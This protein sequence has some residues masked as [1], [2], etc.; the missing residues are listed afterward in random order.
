[1]DKYYQ[2]LNKVVISIFSN[3][4]LISEIVSNLDNSNIDIA[5]IVRKDFISTYPTDPFIISDFSENIIFSNKF[6]DMAKDI[7]SLFFHIKDKTLLVKEEAYKS[8]HYL[9]SSIDEY[10]LAVSYIISY[11]EENKFLQSFIIDNFIHYLPSTFLYEDVVHLFSNKF[12]SIADLH[13]HLGGSLR[14]EYRLNYL[15]NNPKKSVKNLAKLTK[16]DLPSSIAVERF[17]D[18]GI[19]NLF[20]ILAISERL[21]FTY[22]DEDSSY[23][24]QENFKDILQLLGIDKNLF[25]REALKLLNDTQTYDIRKK[26]SLIR[27]PQKTVL[28]KIINQIKKYLFGNEKFRIFYIDKLITL[29]ALLLLREIE[30]SE[31]TGKF[32]SN[33]RNI[34]LLYIHIKNIFKSFYIHQYEK[35]GLGFFSTYSKSKFRRDKVLE[36]KNYIAESILLSKKDFPDINLLIEGRL[37]PFYK[38]GLRKKRN[39]FLQEKDIN[40]YKQAFREFNIKDFKIV[41][42]FTKEKDNTDLYEKTKKRIKSQAF[43]VIEMLE[44]SNNKNELL[45]LINGFDV[46][47]K[48]YNAP[49]EVFAPLFRFLKSY[50]SLI[51]KSFQYTYH[52]GEDFPSILTGLRH[53]FESI[54]FL[55]LS[56]GDRLS[57]LVALG[58]NTRV[59]NNFEFLEQPLSL[60]DNLIFLY[61]ILRISKLGEKKLDK[62]YVSKLYEIEKV[63][64]LILKQDIFKDI[65]HIDM[66]SL[67]DGWLLRRNCLLEIKNINKA[68]NKL[69]TGKLKVSI[70]RKINLD[71]NKVKDNDA[72]VVYN[73]FYIDEYLKNEVIN[74]LSKGGKKQILYIKSSIPDFLNEEF[75]Q[76]NFSLSHRLSYNS[77]LFFSLYPKLKEKTQNLR[78]NKTLIEAYKK[79]VDTNLIEIVQDILL[80]DFVS[81]HGITAEVLLTSNMITHNIDNIYNHSLFKFFPVK[82]NLDANELVGLKRKINVILGSDNPGIQNTS[83]INELALIYVY[84]K[85][86]TDEF[87]AED[88]IR[89]IIDTGNYTYNL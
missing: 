43:N 87:F 86:I 77:L 14:Y 56:K 74:F 34:I 9:S 58:T 66:K 53:I 22:C 76:I 73:F 59:L 85:D 81:K 33:L 36:E 51:G 31:I 47:G 21:I 18:Y 63:V 62:I 69:L 71:Y 54:L 27:C 23:R 48:E 50:Q 79:V 4:Q 68:I 17:F 11:M 83:I 75:Y 67:I 40:E 3:K 16:K 78:L 28:S 61:H 15:L 37:T 24:F 45:N 5:S 12:K 32:E 44:K 57:H 52:V 1:M 13:I 49:P 41:F 38:K 64:N 46:A 19:E 30:K 10:I 55:N 35:T 89:K 88:Y 65:S 70:L 29:Y 2:I 42:H 8:F 6:F 39:A 20:L 26:S 72:V 25:F 80:E 60:L 84:V 7:S 82:D